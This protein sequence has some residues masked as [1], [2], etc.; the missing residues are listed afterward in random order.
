[1][2]PVNGMAILKDVRIDRTLLGSLLERTGVD[3]VYTFCLE[4]FENDT[5]AYGRLLTSAA[6]LKTFLPVLQ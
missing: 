4:G 6:S 2:A 1:M 5:E 3:A